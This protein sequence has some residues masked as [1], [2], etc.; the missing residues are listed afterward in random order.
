MCAIFGIYQT[1]PDSKTAEMSRRALSTMQH[2]G[3][4]GE[5]LWTSPGGKVIL[6][7]R[8]LSIL[9]LTDTAAQPMLSE[10]A[11]Q[12]IT[13]NGEIYNYRQLRERLAIH[14][15]HWKST[16][17]TEV[18]ANWLAIKGI[19][20]LND[21]HG[22]FAF[23]FWNQQKQQLLLARDPLG[24]KPLYYV[25]IETPHGIN[26]IFASEIRAL[27]ATGLVTRNLSIQGVTSFLA[28]GAVQAPYTI[29]RDI[30]ELLPGHYLTLESDGIFEIKRYWHHH[31][32]EKNSPLDV[33][34]R[35]HNI[36]EGLRTAVESHLISDVP[37]GTFLS[38]G[39]DSSAI[40]ALAA[41]AKPGGL[42]SLSVG[43][44]EH[45]RFSET[46]IAQS[47]AKRYATTHTQIDISE[48]EVLSLALQALN[49][50]DQPSVD[51]MNTYI[52]AHAAQQAGLKVVLSGLGG[53]ELFAGYPSFIDVPEIALM[54]RRAGKLGR[55]WF[56]TITRVTQSLSSHRRWQKLYGLACTTPDIPGVYKIRRRLFSD[57]HLSAFLG[58]S[59]AELVT[60]DANYWQQLCDD[61]Q[62]LAD[63]DAVSWLESRLYMANTL[64]RDS[65]VMGMANH[66]EIRVPFLHQPFVEMIQQAGP[67]V[68][69]VKPRPK[70]AL[71]NEIKP[72]LP[73]ETWNRPKQGFELPF[74]TWLQ[75]PLRLPFEQR[76]LKLEQ[77]K[78]L[79][80]LTSAMRY[81]WQLFLAN[82]K[83]VGWTRVWSFFVLTTWITNNQMKL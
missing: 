13:F 15:V 73:E 19:E 81:W 23:G 40:T 67:S 33:N 32:P 31:Y 20:G 53:D 22:M 9:D 39:V 62:S 47:V 2:R 61:V 52:V 64:L 21:L 27:L 44:P 4:D 37:V 58:I 5:G 83:S 68:R 72:F 38:G 28:Y 80:E 79:I 70:S 6:G 74:Q 25:Q 48:T 17:D 60:I 18:L 36:L 10:S 77:D 35:H 8:R 14:N 46:Q 49:A 1:Y 29:V 12:V 54:L 56:K 16:G 71:I 55:Q 76:I 78:Y 24:I 34:H 43:F 42:L 45:H 11:N 66:L 51:G 50:Q 41:T 57:S 63:V 30:R 82:P 26:F 65:D 3:P 69:Q 75:G 59:E 7:H